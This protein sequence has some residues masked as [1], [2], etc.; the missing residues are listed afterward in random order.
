VHT[1]ARKRE[2]SGG[3]KGITVDVRILQTDRR[4]LVLEDECTKRVTYE[5][6]LEVSNSPC[7][8]FF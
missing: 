4:H 7:K 3:H 8:P 5:K 1:C 6:K 2:R